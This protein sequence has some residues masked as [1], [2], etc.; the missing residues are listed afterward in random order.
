MPWNIKESVRRFSSYN[1][2][3]WVLDCVFPKSENPD[4][5]H[6]TEGAVCL[7]DNP[8]QV[9]GWEDI[10]RLFEAGIEQGFNGDWIDIGF[11][12]RADERRID[13]EWHFFETPPQSGFAIKD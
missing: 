2:G 6:S 13:L 8:V 10:D 1:Y 9:L 11:N 3:R 12:R 5:F 7:T 4:D